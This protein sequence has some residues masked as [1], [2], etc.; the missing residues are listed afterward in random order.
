M[1]IM[2]QEQ[3]SSYI[4][5]FPHCDSRRRR[6]GSNENVDVIG[7]ELHRPKKKSWIEREVW[8]K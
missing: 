8:Q 1:K 5:L 6:I 7:T 2:F 3:E 4:A